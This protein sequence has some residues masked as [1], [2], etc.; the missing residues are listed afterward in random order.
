MLLER[1]MGCG[2]SRPAPIIPVQ[3][4]QPCPQLPGTVIRLY[5]PAGATFNVLNLVEITSPSGI[6]LILRLPFLGGSLDD[7]TIAGIQPLI[8]AV[9]NAGGTFQVIE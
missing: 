2:C 8:Q 5:I 1:N 9:Q 4:S 7:N 3:P 6:C